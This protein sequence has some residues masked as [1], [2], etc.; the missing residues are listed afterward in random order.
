MNK[1][2][3]LALALV[4]TA[5]VATSQPFEPRGSAGG[6]NVFLNTRTEGCFIERET[7]QGVVLQIGTER[8]LVEA[9]PDDPIG[10]LSLWMPGDAPPSANPNELLVV[11]IGQNQYIGVAAS[12]TR[13]G[14]H[15]ATVLAS[16]SE[17]GFDLR[18]RRTMEI[19][20]SSGR[21]IQIR[22]NA[23]NI[24]D[25]LDAMMVCQRSVS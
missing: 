8:A 13:D 10:F 19:R 6:W 12:G 7:P 21:E 15:G 5:S 17:L 22:L 9:S 4:T 18:N 23:S 20:S 25:A 14:F 1:T 3:A 2:T 16:N 24:A 11:Q